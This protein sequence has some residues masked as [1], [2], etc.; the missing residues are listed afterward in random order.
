MQVY[1]RPKFFILD[2]VLTF[3]IKEEPVKFVK[4][5]DKSW[6]ILRYISMFTGVMVEDNN[7]YWNIYSILMLSI[8]AVMHIT[9]TTKRIIEKI[10]EYQNQQIINIQ[11]N[12]GTGKSFSEALFLA[13]IN[14]KYDKRLFLDLPVL[15]RKL[16]AQ[17]M[18]CT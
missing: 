4:V 17:N 12:P 9:S 14:P 16:Q 3:S 11:L 15:A 1:A 10:K 2:W 18:L 8:F 7:I 13:T 5:S 6:V